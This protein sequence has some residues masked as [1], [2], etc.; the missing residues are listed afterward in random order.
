[1]ADRFPAL[2]DIT[3]GRRNS[4]DL[5]GVGLS[6]SYRAKL[7]AAALQQTSQFQPRR[8]QATKPARTTAIS[9]LVSVQH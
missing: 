3:G 7:T 6:T 8:D 1:M 4:K 5:L 9:L 2:D